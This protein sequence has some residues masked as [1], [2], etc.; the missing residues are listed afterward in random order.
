MPTHTLPGVRSPT[1]GATTARVAA[2]ASEP[3]ASLSPAIDTSH[4][5][6]TN[7]EYY[8]SL[9]CVLTGLSDDHGA[10]AQAR[11]IQSIAHFATFHHPGCFTDDVVEQCTTILAMRLA[12]QP[13]MGRVT[14]YLSKQS[15]PTVL[16]V[17]TSIHS[18][19]GPPRMLDRWIRLDRGSL[20]TVA[21]TGQSSECDIPSWFI[22]S[23]E[24]RGCGLHVASE[25]ASIRDRFAFLRTVLQSPFDFIFLHHSPNDVAAV[26]A[27]AAAEP[28]GVVAIINQADHAYWLGVGIADAIVNLREPG[29]VLSEQRRMRDCNLM[30]PIPLDMPKVWDRD[31]ARRRLGVAND[32]LVLLT[33]GRP[34]K[35]APLPGRDFFAMVHGIL[36]QHHKARMLVAGVTATELARYYRRDVSHPRLHFLGTVVQPDAIRCAADIYLESFPFGSQTAL[37]EAALAG[38]PTVMAVKSDSPLVAA[39]D[40]ALGGIISPPDSIEASVAM[41][42]FLAQSRSRRESLGAQLERA[43][44]EWH[45]G[46]SW[47]DRLHGLYV[48]LRGIKRSKRPSPTIGLDQSPDDLAVGAMHYS[49]YRAEPAAHRDAIRRHTEGL[50]YAL[51][52][53]D[54]GRAARHVLSRAGSGLG[55]WSINLAME[56]LKLMIS[57]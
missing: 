16:H 24:S 11:I 6:S 14:P 50:V 55:G 42:G 39:H 29:H 44:A 2:S 54:L 49:K 8:K 38:L 28:S 18:D 37:L 1:D 27:V 41:V 52:K 26:S 35:F 33:S 30:L 34:A 22:Q 57:R 56:S 40:F 46:D 19:I 51:R 10:E 36:G 5:L 15:Q 47:L 23:L 13:L 17:I 45:T 20:H 25:S 7:W 32:E 9:R 3:T 21:V 31:G 4:F 48:Q 53:N 12:K 43:V